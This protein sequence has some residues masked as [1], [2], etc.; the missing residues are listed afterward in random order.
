MLIFTVHLTSILNVS[1]TE[2]W[3]IY[4]H[5]IRKSGRIFIFMTVRYTASANQQTTCSTFFSTLYHWSSRW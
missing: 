5:I 1:D 3:I 4:G 2:Y